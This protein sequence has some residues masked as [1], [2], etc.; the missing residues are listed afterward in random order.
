VVTILP[1]GPS[2]GSVTPGTRCGSGA[3]PVNGFARWASASCDQTI[4]PPTGTV[5]VPLHAQYPNQ[6]QSPADLG[7]KGLFLA[8]WGS[9][10]VVPD[11]D[12]QIGVTPGARSAANPGVHRSADSA[13]IAGRHESRCRRRSTYAVASEH[14]APRLTAPNLGNHRGRCAPPSGGRGQGHEDTASSLG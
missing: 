4:L 3:W 10:V 5:D 7:I 13:A 2:G 1:A 8:Y 12:V 6:E 9:S 11:L 14:L